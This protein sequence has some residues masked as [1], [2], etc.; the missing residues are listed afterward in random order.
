MV[1][2]P[3]KA[4]GTVSTTDPPKLLTTGRLAEELGVPIHRIVYIL[5]TRPHIQPRAMAGS[6]RLFERG[7]VAML[8]HE[9]TAID[10]RRCR[11]REGSNDAQ[12]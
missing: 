9:L 12:K 8:R 7:T 10:A 3:D 2:C 4:N 5:R 11:R 1:P 6:L